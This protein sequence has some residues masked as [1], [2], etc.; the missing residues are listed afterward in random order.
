MLDRLN[1]LVNK[2]RGDNS[3]YAKYEILQKYPDCKNV[4]KQIYDPRTNFYVTSESVLKYIENNSILPPNILTIE[5]LITRLEENTIP[6]GNKLLSACASF[7]EDNVEHEEL[8]LDIFDRDL[9]CGVSTKTLN[10]VW[11][12]LIFDFRDRV[13]L[14]VKVKNT[15]DT[16][17]SYFV[18]RKLDGIRCLAFIEE[19]GVKFFSRNGLEFHTLGRLKKDIEENWKGPKNVVLDGELCIMDNEGN[20]NFDKI[21]SF[22][23]ITNYTIHNPTFLA[24]DMYPIRSFYDDPEFNLLSFEEVY[25]LLGNYTKGMEF[26][27]RLPQTYCPTILD[28]MDIELPGHWEGLMLRKN[29]PTKFKRSDNIQKIKNFQDSEFKVLG[30]VPGTKTFD[31]RELPCCSSLM[32]EYKNNFVYVGSGLTDQQRLDWYKDPNE[33]IGRTI[34]VKYH[35]ESID[36]NG[37]YSLKWPTLKA[38]HYTEKE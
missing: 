1:E 24:F 14:A 16:S 3:R 35:T 21:K 38:V 33:I 10:A 20:E 30:T 6:R 27:K 18:S 26:T 2:L 19:H 25:G 36:K 31:E 34:T 11:P 28:A 22:I 17:C 7:L 12:G 32:I 9:N 8:I 23:R 29:L 4:L 37:N 15:Q 5:D 13:P